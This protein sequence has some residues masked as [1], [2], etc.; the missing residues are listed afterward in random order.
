M[1][2]SD[3]VNIPHAEARKFYNCVYPLDWTTYYR[4]V[5]EPSSR[6]FSNDR[7]W[8]YRFTR[9]IK[10]SSQHVSLFQAVCRQIYH[11]TRFLPYELNEFSFQDEM[12]MQNW[13]NNRT[14]GQKRAINTV[15]FDFE[16]RWRS[17]SLPGPTFPKVSR[18]G[19]GNHR[20]VTK[21]YVSTAAVVYTGAASSK[22]YHERLHRDEFTTWVVRLLQK[23]VEDLEFK[24]VD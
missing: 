5:A 15:W 20:G 3:R 4:M 2:L 14:A 13:F 17:Y 22:D 24:F 7:I 9:L 11:E 6:Y 21:V 19:S 8:S 10:S 23:G 16:W 1:Y 18:A 12:T